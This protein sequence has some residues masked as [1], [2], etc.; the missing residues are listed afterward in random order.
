[1]DDLVQFVI[2]NWKVL[3]GAVGTVGLGVAVGAFLSWPS[4][5]RR[6]IVKAALGALHTAY[7]EEL[8]G[9]DDQI[10]ERRKAIEA[11]EKQ[12]RKPEAPPG[13]DAALKQLAQGETGS[14]EAIFEQVLERKKA[15][16]EDAYEEAAAAAR[17]IGELTYFHDTKKARSAYAEALKLDPEDP[18][19]WNRLGLLCARV[20]NLDEAIT[21]FERLLEL[22]NNVGDKRVIAMAY[23]NLGNVYETRGELAKAEEYHRK[24]LALNEELGRKQGMAN[25]YGNLGNVYFTRGKLKKAEEHY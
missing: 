25:Q 9:K 3:F 8:H 21:T 16:G 5:D 18:D 23:G 6:L 13:I 10:Q 11:L 19:G 17:H 12:M 24:S 22:G 2:V 14:A 4:S 15:E 20:G 1:M 7:Y